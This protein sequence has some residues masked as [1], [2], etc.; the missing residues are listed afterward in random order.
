MKPSTSFRPLST[1]PDLTLT[2]SPNR[3]PMA[4]LSQANGRG[5][6]T[7][8]LSHEAVAAGPKPRGRGKSVFTSN[9]TESLDQIPSANAHAA[10]LCKD[11]PTISRSLQSSAWPEAFTSPDDVRTC[12]ERLRTI[13]REIEAAQAK[14]LATA[15]Q[16][17]R[18]AAELE[19]LKTAEKLRR[20]ARRQELQEYVR[21]EHR[22]SEAAMK[23]QRVVRRYLENQQYLKLRQST[24][25][26]L[27]CPL[28]NDI[29][30][31]R[32][33]ESAVKLQRWWQFIKQR[34][35][36]RA[37]EGMA[38][39]LI[40]RYARAWFVRMSKR[41]ERGDTIIQEKLVIHYSASEI[42]S[43]HSLE[44]N[45]DDSL[46]QMNLL[47]AQD[48][49]AVAESLQVIHT[50]LAAEEWVEPAVTNHSEPLEKMNRIFVRLPPPRRRHSSS[51]S[52]P[53]QRMSYISRCPRPSSVNVTLRVSR[54][55]TPIISTGSCRKLS[56]P[57]A[58][59]AQA[60]PQRNRLG[61]LTTQLSTLKPRL[62]KYPKMS[63]EEASRVLSLIPD[64]PRVYSPGVPGNPQLPKAA[65]LSL[66]TGGVEGLLSYIRENEYPEKRLSGVLSVSPRGTKQSQVCQIDSYTR[67]RRNSGVKPQAKHL[68]A[69]HNIPKPRSQTQAVMSARS[70]E[71]N[72]HTGS[73]VSLNK[74]KVGPERTTQEV[75]D[76]MKAMRMGNGSQPNVKTGNTLLG[77]MA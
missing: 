31:T 67:S 10:S 57:A 76:Q 72:Y 68:S 4:A 41:K 8:G 1:R 18:L 38:A 14:K 64:D 37:A 40:Q 52:F 46:H 12:R 17:Q 74:E 77:I 61:S 54:S 24:L 71:D 69:I 36:K 58:N 20:E 55:P 13:D 7:D 62:S 5:A 29:D 6:P 22:R 53:A 63:A 28:H 27:R 60:G 73:P 66:A 56:M 75:E 3:I 34:R 15:A 23:I 49:D 65:R 42:L 39:S 26:S 51:P 47:C 19:A 33:Q 35:T 32:R 2:P 50:P 44:S 30:E 45:S 48:K 25:T 11:L 59:D 16:R 70:K 43:S 9:R 21:T